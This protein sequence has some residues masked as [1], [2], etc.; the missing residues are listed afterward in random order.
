MRYY[1]SGEL[2]EAAI[3]RLLTKHK[4][5]RL[6]IKENFDYYL[7]EKLPVKEL[8]KEG[9]AN[10]RLNTNLAK[11][12]TDMATGYFVGIPPTYAVSAEETKFEKIREVY[13]AND[14]TEINYAIAENMSI[15]GFGYDLTYIDEQKKICIAS[16]NPMTAFLICD[17]S[18]KR[19][20][21]AGVRHWTVR[22]QN[23]SNRI[24]GEIYLPHAIVP[25]YVNAGRLVFEEG[26]WTPFSAPNLT[27]Y[28]NNRFLKG[29]FDAGSKTLINAYNLLQSNV[30][31]DL[32]NVANAYLVL[33]GFEQPDDEDIQVIRKNRVL[34]IPEDGDA[35]YI[36]KNLSG[37]VI[38]NQRKALKEDIMQ[39]TGVPDLSD[40][41]FAQAASGVA[42]EYK[43]YGLNQLW[44]KKKSYMDKALFA[45]MR[46]VAEALNVI[47]SAGIDDV[48]K[49]VT[50]KFSK[51]LPKDSTNIIENAMKMEGQV[52]RKTIHETLEPVTGVTAAD[53]KTRMEKELTEDGGEDYKNAFQTKDDVQEE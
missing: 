12:V 10:N 25:F 43:L 3:L 27:L 6:R 34:G 16:V 38:Q 23:G 24:V 49:I 50:I 37:E 40:E 26:I 39:S 1:Y 8:A 44:S 19:T 21:R 30:S 5:D 45:R 42:Q 32:E 17:D 31:D 51:N 47:E 7:G 13:D 35:K 52:S 9:M 33:L 20:A 14:E 28:P 41:N 29:D 18:V 46:L 11:Y 53:E 2:N 4:N 36:T 48:S 15:C 22:N